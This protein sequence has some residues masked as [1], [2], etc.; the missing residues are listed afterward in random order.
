MQSVGHHTVDILLYAFA[1]VIFHGLLG[2]EGHHAGAVVAYVGHHGARIHHCLCHQRIAMPHRHHCA[3][4]SHALHLTV[5]LCRAAHDGAHIRLIF[6]GH[7]LAGLVHHRGCAYVAALTHIDAVACYRYQSPCRGCIIV[8]KC[9][10]RALTAQ[11]HRAHTVGM[12]HRAAIGVDVKH[13]HIGVFGF[14]HLKAFLQIAPRCAAYLGVDGYHC[15]LFLLF[16]FY[17][18]H[19]QQPQRHHKH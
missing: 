14:G 4:G 17:A 3:V 8:D 11:Y 1:E 9:H 19:H 12:L 7:S 5:L 18:E 10:H 6:V 13:H 15:H 2:G 16:C